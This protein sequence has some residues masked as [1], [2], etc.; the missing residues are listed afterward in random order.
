MPSSFKGRLY[1]FSHTL[2]EDLNYCKINSGYTSNEVNAVQQIGSNDIKDRMKE[3]ME[4]NFNSIC[5][6]KTRL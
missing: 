1:K 3:N 6:R 2:Y 5:K 4:T